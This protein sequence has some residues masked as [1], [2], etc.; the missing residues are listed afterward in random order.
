VL[1]WRAA[2]T[3]TSPERQ[4][5]YNRTSEMKSEQVIQRLNTTP[6]A[7]IEN[8]QEHRYWMQCEGAYTY[9]PI[10]RTDGRL[11]AVDI[12][13]V[14]T[15]PSIPSQRIAPDRYFSEVAV[16]QRIDVLEEQLKML[17]TRRAF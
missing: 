12:L 17:A 10:C 8:S 11:M 3:D 2:N 1:T 6:E 15:H 5:P 9:Q 14:V 4:S 16:R 13:S 7:C